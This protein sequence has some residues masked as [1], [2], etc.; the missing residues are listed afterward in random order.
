M[1][2]RQKQIQSSKWS[3]QRKMCATLK[4]LKILNYSNLCW[5]CLSRSVFC[6]IMLAERNVAQSG[7]LWETLKENVKNIKS[8]KNREALWQRPAR[9]FIYVRCLCRLDNLSHLIL[10]SCQIY[11]Q[12][13]WSSIEYI[14]KNQVQFTPTSKN[15]IINCHLRFC[16]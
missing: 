5:C 10:K 6:R 15:R 8:P 1:G 3:G 12:P 11:L 14:L 16:S 4:C 2:Y 13:N 7:R 9:C